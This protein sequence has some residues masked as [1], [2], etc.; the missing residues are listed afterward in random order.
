MLGMI[1]KLYLF[2][3]ISSPPL[4]ARRIGIEASTIFNVDKLPATIQAFFALER[5]F[6]LLDEASL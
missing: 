1:N 5:A 4:V 6:Q 2:P 3:F